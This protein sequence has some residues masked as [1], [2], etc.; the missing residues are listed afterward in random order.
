MSKQE[1]SVQEE[2]T[3]PAGLYIHIPFCRS[4]CPYCDFY[5]IASPTLIPRWFESLK[6]EILLYRGV[7]ESFDTV[8]LGGGTP[9]ILETSAIEEI[10]DHIKI[11]FNLREDAEITIEANPGDLDPEK[12]TGLKYVGINR[13]NIGIQSFNDH[14]LYFLGRRH[15][16][17]DSGR[18]LNDLKNAGFNNIG[19]D[20]IYGL[21]GQTLEDWKAT[22]ERALFFKPEHISCY[23]LTIEGKTLFHSM[24]NKGELED[25]DEDLAS[26][27]F[28][29]TSEFLEKRGY[30][31]YEVSNFS[32]G[33]DFMSRHNIK[34]WK[35]TPYLGLGPSA[36]SFDGEKRWWNH[37]SVK[38]YCSILEKNMPPVDDSETLSKEQAILEKISL[39][40]RTLC[41][42][43]REYLNCIN[44]ALENLQRLEVSGHIEIVNDRIV[45]TKKGLLIADQL[46]LYIIN[47]R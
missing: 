28:L 16:A 38:K 35:R 13:I 2:N 45:P 47:D 4:K 34:Y 44:G 18:V 23:Q 30:L 19:I 24:K 20:L 10:L 42:I 36:H 5:S 27:F 31:H 32:R 43:S 21:R 11:N 39:G 15:R 26:K 8:Y 6:K 9:S 46:P 3:S 22:L 37:R 29:E 33:M 1:K 25:L 40:L 12:I 17:V 14:E 7:F 41:G